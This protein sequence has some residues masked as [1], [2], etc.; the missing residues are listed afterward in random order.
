MYS[1]KRITGEQMRMA[2][3]LLKKNAAEFGT[4][5]VGV[6]KTTVHRMESCKGALTGDL[7]V[8]E[9]VQLKLIAVLAEIGWE[10]TED[11]GIRPAPKIPTS[12]NE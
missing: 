6:S 2:R 10:L 3:A 1:M 8:I 12:S 9:S 4:G 11:G 5:V 7:S